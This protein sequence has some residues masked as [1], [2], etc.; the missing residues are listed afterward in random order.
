MH[1]LHGRL[2]HQSLKFKFL[3]KEQ[4]VVG[5]SLDRRKAITGIAAGALVVPLMRSTP[6]LRR[7]AMSISSVRRDRWTKLIFSHAAFAAENA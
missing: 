4:E 2:P 1:E 3:R 5:T 7:G 6:G